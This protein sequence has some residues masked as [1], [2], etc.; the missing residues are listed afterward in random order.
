MM[1]G[2]RRGPY[3]RGNKARE[4][5]R[6]AIRLNPGLSRSE[7]IRLTGLSWGVVA[8]HVRAMES[9]NEVKVIHIGRR[10]YFHLE[11]GEMSLFPVL[12]LLRTEALAM[13]I[14]RVLNRN[15]AFSVQE[16]SDRLTISAK[17][18]RR[19]LDHMVE[20]DLVRKTNTMRTRFELT[21]V[22]LTWRDG[23]VVDSSP[24]REKH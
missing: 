14:L 7:I 17:T 24:N 11:E 1:F 5:I 4:A 19:H 3:Q 13:E 10:P 16:L 23:L 12:R 22:P 18:V 21:H 20:A 6:E 15:G 2:A 8:H 9:R